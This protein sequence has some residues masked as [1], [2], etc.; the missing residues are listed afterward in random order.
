M[1][2]YKKYNR[3]VFTTY[4]QDLDCPICGK[5]FHPRTKYI[6]TCSKEC[7]Y[8]LRV[9]PVTPKRS[10]AL[11]GRKFT[12]EHK[13]KISKKLKG[14]NNGSWRG[15]ISYTR[16]SRRDRRHR[17]WR[18]AVFKKDNY[19]CQNCGRVG[20]YLEAD[21]I[22]PFALFKKLRYEI[23]NGQTLCR[24]CHYKKTSVEQKKYFSNLC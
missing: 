11:K 1:G 10:E 4:L 9:V 18:L 19:T 7:G 16:N 17:K 12:Q 8:K 22:K 6:K 23:S 20:G 3:G 24:E 21:H 15:G 13:D 14:S 2:R 5:R